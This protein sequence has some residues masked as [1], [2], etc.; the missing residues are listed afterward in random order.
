MYI[1]HCT[2]VNHIS[3]FMNNK[4]TQLRNGKQLQEGSLFPSGKK[5][6]IVERNFETVSIIWVWY[7]DV[8]YKVL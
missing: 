6:E 8:F 1:I 4:E 5:Q 3:Q 7:G 2:K